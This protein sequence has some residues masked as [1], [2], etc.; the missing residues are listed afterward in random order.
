MAVTRDTANGRRFLLFVNDGTSAPPVAGSVNAVNLTLQVNV[1]PWGLATGI[2][3]P[4]RAGSSAGFTPVFSESARCFFFNAAVC[5]ADT[6]AACFFHSQVN[7]AAAGSYGECQQLIAVP[8]GGLISIN[9]PANSVVRLTSP[10]SGASQSNVPLA[11]AA[12]ATLRAGASASA[13]FGAQPTLAVATTTGTNHSATAAAFVRFQLPATG[14]A[15]AQLTAAILELT[16]ASA[17]AQS[18]VMTVVGVSCAPTNAG[19]AAWT[20]ASL[21]WSAATFAFNA[22]RAPISAAITTVAQNWVRFDNGNVIAG[23]VTV[24][25]GTAAGAPLEKKTPGSSVVFSQVLPPSSHPH[26]HSL[27]RHRQAR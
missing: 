17:P 1:S 23:H 24:A 5:V 8:A 13:A 15:P 16:V 27:F 19:A 10:I 26:P 4:V 25:A 9:V 21:T 2:L 22:S 3:L 7:V 11:P 12:D 18:M 14:I 6:N 20:D